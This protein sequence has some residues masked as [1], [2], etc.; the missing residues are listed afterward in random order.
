MIA[1]KL[2]QIQPTATATNPSGISG[3]TVWLK[4]DAGL[5]DGSGGTITANGTAIATWQNQAS[6][7]THYNQATSGL[8]P[9]YRDGANGKNGLPV[10]DF[11]G[12]STQ[13][14]THADTS[15][16]STGGIT[17]FTIC[18]W[19]SGQVWSANDGAG[20]VSYP[21]SG[22]HP[23]YITGGDGVSNF[24]TT[25][26]D[27]GY[28]G[29]NFTKFASNVNVSYEYYPYGTPSTITTAGFASRGAAQTADCI[30]KY[31]YNSDYFT[32]QIGELIIYNRK[33]TDTECAT[34]RTYLLNR[35]GMASIDNVALL[36]HMDGT[37]GSTTFTDS[38]SNN[39]TVTAAN[40]TISTTQAKYGG[41]SGSF[42][43]TS[44]NAVVPSSTLF[45][46]G[47]GDFTIEC[48]IYWLGGGGSPGAIFT[49]AFPTD[50]QGVFIGLLSS[51]AFNY[52]AGNGT[53]A[54]NS[55]TTSNA[56]SANQWYHL[57]Y[58]R[59][60]STFTVYVNGVASGSTTSS[61][62]LTNSNNQALIGGRNVLGQYFRGFIDDLR[63]TKGTARYAANFTPTGPFPNS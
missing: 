29:W 48:W 59:S 28:T 42:T 7:G 3:L 26:D 2:R 33:L 1:E 30:G 40:A 50:S 9:T 49:T 11:N 51:G 41:S 13:S 63:V 58:V 23:R 37:N 14:L 53:W 62:T 17:I 27:S 47:V 35:W 46:F 25:N 60:G 54:F 31:P 34:I 61:P 55:T 8:R 36:L 12:A 22:Y 19:T 32:G 45:N 20:G 16:Y 43:G 44:S 38:S 56:I 18:K 4:A 57:A 10:V 21:I 15:A 52:L 39:L 5:I 24:G 6:G